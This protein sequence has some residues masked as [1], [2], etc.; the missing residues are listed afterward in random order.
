M[1]GFAGARGK[2]N[3]RTHYNLRRSYCKDL[4]ESGVD[5]KAYERFCG[6][7]L[8]AASKHFQQMDEIRAQKAVPKFLEALSVSDLEET[9]PQFCPRLP[10]KLAHSDNLRTLE[11]SGDFEPQTLI[12]KDISQEMKNPLQE[13]A[14]GADRGN[15]IRTCDPLLPKQMR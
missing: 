10:H 13:V 5:A 14:R 12:E 7:N 1:C 4:M 3:I 2:I 9:S 11:D 15:R 6:H 8:R